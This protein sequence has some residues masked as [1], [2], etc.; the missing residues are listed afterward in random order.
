[1][2]P[3]KFF[4]LFNVSLFSWTV[5]CKYISRKVSSEDIFK[6]IEKYQKDFQ[7]CGYHQTL[8]ELRKLA[9]EKEKL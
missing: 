4:P 6:I 7:V 3:E 9:G 8:E 2:R 1:M 5:I